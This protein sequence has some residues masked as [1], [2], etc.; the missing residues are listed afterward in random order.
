MIPNW[1]RSISL[2]NDVTLTQQFLILTFST[3][4]LWRLFVGVKLKLL[5][6]YI[7]SNKC[8]TYFSPCFFT[9]CTNQLS[10]CF[11]QALYF[12]TGRQHLLL[13]GSH[14]LILVWKLYSLQFKFRKHLVAFQDSS[15]LCQAKP[16][17][18]VCPAV[19][20]WSSSGVFRWRW[21]R[22]TRTFPHF[23]QT[24]HKN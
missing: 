10:C 1:C 15:F 9:R 7:C 6:W 14:S 17:S 20:P 5:I 13:P 16:N 24:L 21:Y 4:I 23:Q 19:S 3:C 8:W 18:V 12:E 2:P 22:K 11:I